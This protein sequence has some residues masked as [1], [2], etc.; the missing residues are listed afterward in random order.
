MDVGDCSDAGGLPQGVQTN[1][2]Q[3]RTGEDPVTDR[4]FEAG[5]RWYLQHFNRHAE[6]LHRHRY[7]AVTEGDQSLEDRK[8]GENAANLA[9]LPSNSTW[10][11]FEKDVFFGSLARHSRLR[12]DLIAAEVQTKTEAEVVWYLE[13]LRAMS[14]SLNHDHVPTRTRRHARPWQQGLAPPARQVSEDFI[15][16]EE[17][18]AKLVMHREKEW[19]RQG[20]IAQREVELKTAA[21]RQKNA[22]RSKKPR[23]QEYEQSQLGQQTNQVV[24]LEQRNF[25]EDFLSD[26]N[27]E[28]M[29]YLSKRF[30]VMQK[31]ELRTNASQALAEARLRLRTSMPQ[32]SS[33]QQ[34]TQSL[35]APHPTQRNG[36]LDPAVGAAAELRSNGVPGEKTAADAAQ[37]AFEDGWAEFEELPQKEREKLE[38]EWQEEQRRAD[39]HRRKKWQRTLEEQDQYETLSRRI[40][41]R[42]KRRQK[43]AEKLGITA[44]PGTPASRLKFLIL[45][46]QQKPKDD[47]SAQHL[48]AQRNKPKTGGRS[49]ATPSRA[50][51]PDKAI[52]NLREVR[53]EQEQLADEVIASGDQLPA[54]LDVAKQYKAASERAVTLGIELFDTSKLANIML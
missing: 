15:A 49:I 24:E 22:R 29:V 44:D 6:Y 53:P 20:T 46:H 9:V 10:T 36:E 31:E 33:P 25:V 39:L 51:K 21:A 52:A 35:H 32:P 19:S 13:T 23:Q 50:P 37:V 12:P 34:G 38:L 28:K 43:H 54:S 1:D 7:G 41:T 4:P 14:I 45:S 42:T 17:R 16:E 27:K 30:D 18:L 11:A 48:Q 2:S 3:E 40:D 8:D 47:A 5:E 26:M